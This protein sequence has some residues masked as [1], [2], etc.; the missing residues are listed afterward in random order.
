M[1]NLCRLHYPGMVTLPS[2]WREIA[3]TWENFQFA[4]DTDY[5]TTQG[6]V[7]HDFWVSFFFI[8]GFFFITRVLMHILFCSYVFDFPKW[9]TT[10]VTHLW[11]LTAM[12]TRSSRMQFPMLVFRQTINITRKF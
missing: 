8:H 6:I 3:T 11:S 5:G 12:L 4:P 9:T 10:R 2:G 7:S 1:G